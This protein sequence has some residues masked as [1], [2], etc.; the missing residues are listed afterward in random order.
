MV[1]KLF[2]TDAGLESYWQ[3]VNP[4]KKPGNPLKKN[5]G[6]PSKKEFSF[7]LSSQPKILKI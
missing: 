1:K 5:P 2:N 6:N 7:R 4:N 3:I